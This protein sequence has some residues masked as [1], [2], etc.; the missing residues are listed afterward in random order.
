MNPL[1]LLFTGTSRK[2]KR[3]R[4]SED[5]LIDTFAFLTR[6][7]LAFQIEHVCRRFHYI[8]DNA[9]KYHPFIALNKLNCDCISRPAHQFLRPKKYVLERQKYEIFGALGKRYNPQS[10]YEVIYANLNNAER[11]E[12]SKFSGSI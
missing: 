7:Q 12:K 1:Y 5:I 9:F 4:I 6:H 8:I 11:A 10:P 3:I 2:R